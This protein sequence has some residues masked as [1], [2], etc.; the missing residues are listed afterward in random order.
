[1]PAM[2]SILAPE[3]TVSPLRALTPLIVTG[4][5]AT[6]RP[7][8]IS[9]FAAKAAASALTFAV[10]LFPVGFAATNTWDKETTINQAIIFLIAKL[11]VI[12]AL[13]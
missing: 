8:G 5:S 3:K 9:A 11:F 12:T 2:V 10:V 7:K 6:S 1:M 13:L 4:P